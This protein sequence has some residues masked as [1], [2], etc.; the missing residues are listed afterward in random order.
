MRSS[1]RVTVF[2]RK[3]LHFSVEYFQREHVRP[4]MRTKCVIGEATSFSRYNGANVG[5]SKKK[6]NKNKYRTNLN[7]KSPN[8]AIDR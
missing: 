5:H 2:L 8:M 1:G 4:C 7:D 6:T 3:H